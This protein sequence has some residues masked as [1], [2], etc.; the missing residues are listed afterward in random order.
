MNGSLD[1]DVWGAIEEARA[2]GSQSELRR[3]AGDLWFMDAVAP[4]NGAVL[5]FPNGFLKLLGHPPQPFFLN[6]LRHRGIEFVAG[7][8][9]VGTNA[10]F[11]S[12]ILS[13]RRRIRR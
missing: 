4:E 13:V 3:I 5:V 6:D 10:I 8:S 12:Q 9:V 7:K 2:P 1:S 11:A